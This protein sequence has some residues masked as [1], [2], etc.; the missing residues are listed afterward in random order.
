MDLQNVGVIIGK[1]NPFLFQRIKKI[2]NEI[3]I[4]VLEY[5]SKYLLDQFHRRL[6]GYDY[7]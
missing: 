2:T 5:K 4:E 3:N 7:V 6:S 1:I